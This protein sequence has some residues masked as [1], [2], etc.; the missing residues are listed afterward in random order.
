[1]TRVGCRNDV[2]TACAVATGNK[3]WVVY[4]IC[5]FS[6]R[7]GNFDPHRYQIFRPILMKLKIK[8]RIRDINTHMQNLVKIC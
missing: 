7:R 4:A 8:K 6:G 5:L 2:I 1:M 3:L